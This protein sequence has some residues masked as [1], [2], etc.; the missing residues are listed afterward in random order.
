[1]VKLGFYI[2]EKCYKGKVYRNLVVHMNFP[3]PLHELLL[4]L[5]DRKIIDVR[6]SREGKT[7]TIQL[8]EE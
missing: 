7:I 8:T 2:N 3:K 5:Q 4:G 6:G 1:M